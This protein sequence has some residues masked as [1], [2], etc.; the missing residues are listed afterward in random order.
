MDI[1]SDYKANCNQN[2]RFEVGKR[3]VHI[4]WTYQEGGVSPAE[5]LPDGVVCRQQE[6]EIKHTQLL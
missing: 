6:G 3:L 4:I 5:V 1:Q 2:K